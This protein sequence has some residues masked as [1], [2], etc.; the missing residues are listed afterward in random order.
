MQITTSLLVLFNQFGAE[1][2]QL[3][4]SLSAYEHLYFDLELYLP[5][6][7]EEEFFDLLD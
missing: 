6:L 7:H 4:S 3:V 1:S 2:Y 5:I